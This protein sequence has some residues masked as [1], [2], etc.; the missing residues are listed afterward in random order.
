MGI[1]SSSHVAGNLAV[2]NSALG[3][4]LSPPGGGL[5]TASYYVNVMN[6]ILAAAAAQNRTVTIPDINQFRSGLLIRDWAAGTIGNPPEPPPPTQTGVRQVTSTE[7][8][9][10]PA[11]VTS[12]MFSWVIAGGGAGGTGHQAAAGGAGGSGGSG[13]YERWRVVSCNPGDTFTF[14]IG[15]GG[16]PLP[17]DAIYGAQFSGSGGDTSVLLN[18]V[19]QIIV[20]GGGGGQC[21]QNIKATVNQAGGSAG[22]PNGQPGQIGPGAVGDKGSAAGNAGANGPITGAVGG[23]GGTIGA[24]DAY[25]GASAGKPGQGYGS[26]GGGAGSRDRVSPYAWAGGRGAPGFIEYAYPNP[27][28]QNWGSPPF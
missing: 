28:H 12:V 22:Q 14:N 2:Y 11:G 18:G 20:T 25:S 15:A 7:N 8:W 17:A 9:V 1:I 6:A 27:G 13:G 21:A 24:G 26:G 4:S 5:I 16:Q 10:V 3:L 19:A 23:D